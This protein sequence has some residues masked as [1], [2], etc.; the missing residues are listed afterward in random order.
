M[1]KAKNGVD[2]NLQNVVEDLAQPDINAYM[3]MKREQDKADRR[4]TDTLSVG[5]QH[6]EAEHHNGTGGNQ[7]R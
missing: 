5:S 3:N 1:T 2:K 4:H 6:H 7:P